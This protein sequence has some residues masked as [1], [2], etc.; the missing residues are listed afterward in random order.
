VP[1]IEQYGRWQKAVVVP[2]QLEANGT[3]STNK[4]G[5]TIFG[6]P[7][8]INVRFT[9]G[10]REERDA[11]GNPVSI[12]GDAVLPSDLP[13]VVG[14]LLFAG[15][16]SSYPAQPNDGTALWEVLYYKSAG[17]LNMRFFRRNV[18]FSRYKGKIPVA[19]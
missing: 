1:S 9:W 16:L 6:T 18:S 15:P 12:D 14:S 13:V 19:N 10:K 4:D 2:V 3:R 8:E 11:K 7:F 5:E 17:D